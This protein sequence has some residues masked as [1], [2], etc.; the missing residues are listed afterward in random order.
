MFQSIFSVFLT[1]G[2]NLDFSSFCDDFLQVQIF[3]VFSRLIWGHDN[4]MNNNCNPICHIII[5]YKI[6]NNI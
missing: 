5:Y 3:H 2:F 4:Y 6:I 1:H